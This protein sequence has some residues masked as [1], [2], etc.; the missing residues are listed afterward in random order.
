LRENVASSSPGDA[1]IGSGTPSQRTRS[2]QMELEAAL[3][4]PA[5]P[6]PIV[7]QNTIVSRKKSERIS[8]KQQTPR[9][10]D[11]G[12]ARH[13]A[14]GGQGF[15]FCNAFDLWDGLLPDESAKVSSTSKTFACTANHTFYSHPTT[16]QRSHWTLCTVVEEMWEDEIDI[17]DDDSL[18]DS[19]V[20]SSTSDTD[21]A[22]TGI[23]VEGKGEVV[24]RQNQLMDR[25]LQQ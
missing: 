11:F 6:P 1:A 24:L 7:S 18:H 4:T 3:N 2:Q 12:R 15:L 16:M 10:S 19:S 9:C 21:T 22:S 5:R 13:Y 20:A 25:R 8:R 17:I 23:K 14:F